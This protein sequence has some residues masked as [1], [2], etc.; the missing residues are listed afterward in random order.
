MTHV[1]LAPTRGSPT[2]ARLEIFL[3]PEG[4]TFTFSL[5]QKALQE[6]C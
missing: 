5:L 4:L 1:L 2:S 6:L 3:P